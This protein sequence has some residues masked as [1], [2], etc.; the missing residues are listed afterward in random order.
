M[1]EVM[2]EPQLMRE[3]MDLFGSKRWRTIKL[4]N[5]N[6][7]H[8]LK[9][10][11]DFIPWDADKIRNWMNKVKDDEDGITPAKLETLWTTL[12]PLSRILGLL[13]PDE[14]ETLKEKME[15]TMDDLVK[16]VIRPNERT[17][18]PPLRSTEIQERRTAMKGL[19]TIKYT[20]TTVRFGTGCRGRTS[21]MQYTSPT[22]R[23]VTDRMFEFSG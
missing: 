6:M 12:K 13:N 23:K 17:M 9:V 10:E 8:T 5:A 22:T 16:S 14:Q 15:A 4:Y 21:D 19:M 3:Y 18:S 20:V 1:A 11:P 7:E 2:H